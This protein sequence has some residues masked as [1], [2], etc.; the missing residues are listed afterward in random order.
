M[1]DTFSKIRILLLLLA[2]VGIALYLPDYLKKRDKQKDIQTVK[3]IFNGRP[4]VLE[5]SSKTCTTCRQMKPVIEQLKKDFKGRV[6]FVV[7]DVESARAASLMQKYPAQYLPSFYVL[8]SESVVVEHFE[9]A[10]SLPMFRAMLHRMLDRDPSE[11]ASLGIPFTGRPLVLV[12][13]EQGNE[14]S[15]ATRPMIEKTATALQGKVDFVEWPLE[16]PGARAAAEKYEA[17]EFPAF[18]LFN[19]DEEVADTLSGAVTEK[20]LK[21]KVDGLLK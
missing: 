19:A 10:Q 15:D 13:T 16:D 8:E 5:Y 4:V 18:I 14:T 11:A 12:F 9:G 1:R 17:G 2:A 7:V 20:Q 21:E 3:S 6:D